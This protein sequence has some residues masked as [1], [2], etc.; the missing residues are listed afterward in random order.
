MDHTQLIPS[1][2]GL[3]H[4]F[5]L[6]TVDFNYH[7]QLPASTL[8]KY[9]T[10]ARWKGFAT[11][12]ALSRMLEDEPG[13][14]VV[15]KVQMIRFLRPN[16]CSPASTLSVIQTP[17]AVG[18]TSMT[19]AYEFFDGDSEA[20]AQVLTICVLC[21][22]GNSL[23]LPDYVAQDLVWR[24]RCLELENTK[25]LAVLSTAISNAGNPAVVTSNQRMTHEILVRPSDTDRRG[26]VN[27]VRLAQ[28]FEDAVMATKVPDLIYLELLSDVRPKTFCD[29]VTVPNK[30]KGGSEVISLLLDRETGKTLAR[31]YMSWIAK[32]IQDNH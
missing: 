16:K 12:P 15:A 30:E 10:D 6:S 31:G 4:D 9:A 21:K 2:P 13:S 25:D 19:L 20:F 24:H 1:V 29:I 14:D 22:E 5:M 27:N 32:V 3:R 8:L 23:P 7:Q 17:H 11:W 18:N 26:I 28:F